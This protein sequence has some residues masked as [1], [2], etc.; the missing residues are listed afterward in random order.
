MNKQIKEML[1]K[2]ISHNQHLTND[3]GD[4][5]DEESGMFR[6]FWT[7]IDRE[8]EIAQYKESSTSPVEDFHRV[9]DDLFILM[10]QT[11]DELSHID[12]RQVDQHLKEISKMVEMLHIYWELEKRS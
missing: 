8:L 10:M 1:E 7:K 5:I 4:L 2:I 3:P 12:D 11:N 6:E 9:W